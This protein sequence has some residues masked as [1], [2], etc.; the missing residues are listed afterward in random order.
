[1]E[2]FTYI[3]IYATKGIEYLIVIG[4]LFT[5]IAFWR[6]LNVSKLK[7]ISNAVFEGI[8]KLSELIEGFLNLF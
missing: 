1:M 2:Q 8:R 4:F 6:F 7:P 5:L 3:D